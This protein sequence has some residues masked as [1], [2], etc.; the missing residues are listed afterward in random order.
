MRLS[1]RIKVYEHCLFLQ[2]HDRFKFK[3]HAIHLREIP[4]FFATRLKDSDNILNIV[5]SITTRHSDGSHLKSEI[6]I[7]KENQNTLGRD[8]PV[9][10]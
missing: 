4:E 6:K 2:V 10:K 9:L 3:L 1:N 8:S 5:I 7:E